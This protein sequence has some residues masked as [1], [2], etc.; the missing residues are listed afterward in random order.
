MG[1]KEEDKQN[2]KKVEE[3]QEPERSPEEKERKELEEILTEIP[4]KPVQY[5]ICIDTLTDGSRFTDEQINIIRR[6]AKTVSQTLLRIEQRIFKTEVEKRVA[7]HEAEAKVLSNIPE[8]ED[9]IESQ[10]K[11]IKKKL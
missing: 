10:K 4:L 5:A 11:K 3:P 7:V 6:F 8:D 1:Q 9:K 2:E